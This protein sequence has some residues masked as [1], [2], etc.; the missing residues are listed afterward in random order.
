MVNGLAVANPK[1]VDVLKHQ[2]AVKLAIGDLSGAEAI[3]KELKAM[4]NKAANTLLGTIY[5]N[6]RNYDESVSAFQKNYME[7]PN[8]YQALSA[9]I[10][11]LVNADRKLEA[12]KM[13]QQVVNNNPD[14]L[15]PKLLL[16]KLLIHLHDN[17]AAIATYKQIIQTHPDTLDAY[18]QLGELLS[19]TGRFDEAE[20]VL[21]E[22]IKAVKQSSVLT[23]LLAT[24]YERKGDYDKAIA[25]YADLIQKEP[26]S[27]VAKNNFISLITDYKTDMVLLN[28]A[29]A[30]SKDLISTSP[31]ILDT[32]GWIAYKVG[33]FD[34]S[35]RALQNASDAAPK[36]ALFAYHLGMAQAALSDKAGAKESLQRALKL[37]ANNQ[38]VPVDLIN[39]KIRE[40]SDAA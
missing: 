11:S 28:K 12:Q 9:L 32:V 30:L 37:K 20:Q 14:N 22:G 40:L 13:L 21:N 18:Q 19:D 31:F 1:D 6:E 3:A 4:D 35:K 24:N 36:V 23:Q 8:D 17:N 2:A 16:A 5:M 27:V 39:K 34:E 7:T 29:Y 26:D 15:K 25:I 38:E 10:K 33:K